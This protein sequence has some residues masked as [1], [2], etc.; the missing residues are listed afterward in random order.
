M[1][2]YVVEISHTKQGIAKAVTEKPDLDGARMLYHQVLS[3]MLAN[4]NVTF[5]ICTILDNDGQQMPEFTETVH[6]NENA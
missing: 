5:G 1:L 6:K 3:S 2:Y 4:E